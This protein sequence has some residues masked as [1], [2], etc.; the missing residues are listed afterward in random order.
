MTTFKA[1]CST[2]VYFIAPNK[3]KSIQS[4][5]NNHFWLAVRK[6]NSKK[7]QTK[8]NPQ[9]SKWHLYCRGLFFLLSVLNSKDCLN[10]SVLVFFGNSKRH[11]KIRY[12]H[13]HLYLWQFSI[14]VILSPFKLICLLLP[15]WATA[16]KSVFHNIQSENT[17][18]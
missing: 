2:A 12:E 1:L 6:P 17:C 4:F 5:I 7:T 8:N 11:Y 14:V 16:N 3:S 15:H 13:M 10:T 18:P 9:S